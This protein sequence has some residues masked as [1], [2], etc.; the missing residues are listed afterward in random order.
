LAILVTPSLSRDEFRHELK[1]WRDGV[2]GVTERI[3]WFL[4]SLALRDFIS[5]E[6]YKILG[7]FLLEQRAYATQLSFLEEMSSQPGLL[8]HY[9]PSYRPFE[10]TKIEWSSNSAYSERRLLESSIANN[11]SQ[12]YGKKATAL[13]EVLRSRNRLA[14]DE[15]VALFRELAIAS[16]HILVE[17]YIPRPYARAFASQI[18]TT[19]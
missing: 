4:F 17:K 1:H 14:Y 7:L 11:F 15:T 13:L 6:E 18:I 2:T 12:L 19:Q 10:T 9:P 8:A 5:E 3:N 16:K